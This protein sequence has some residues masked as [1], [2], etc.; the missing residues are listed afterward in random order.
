MERGQGLCPFCG[1]SQISYSHRYIFWV[2]DECERRFPSPG[3]GPGKGAL[4]LQKNSDEIKTEEFADL[5]RE[6]RTKRE[7]Q[8]RGLLP[9]WVLLIVIIFILLIAALVTWSLKGDQI[10]QFFNDYTGLLNP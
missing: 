9:G 6:S 2:C 10:V 3:Y 5:G 8:R 7:R 4:R 1:S